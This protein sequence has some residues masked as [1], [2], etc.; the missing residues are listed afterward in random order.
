[1]SLPTPPRRLLRVAALLLETSWVQTFSFAHA[2]TFLFICYFKIFQISSRV[3]QEI[4]A[5]VE[6]L[7]GG[8]SISAPF[9]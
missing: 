3:K 1:M 4:K 6:D 7:M 2:K 5:I 8:Q 9:Y